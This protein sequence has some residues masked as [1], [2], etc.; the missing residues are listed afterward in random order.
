MLNAGCCE[1]KVD[2]K[3]A[4]IDCKCRS[5]NQTVKE[6]TVLLDRLQ[7]LLEMPK[8]GQEACTPP[9]QLNYLPDVLDDIISQVS[10]NNEIFNNLIL[11]LEEQ[12][13]EIKIL[14]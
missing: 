9:P 4:I 11:K 7:G 5:L 12:I 8:L 3:E 6:N 1:A 2:R 10:K 13:G 14:A